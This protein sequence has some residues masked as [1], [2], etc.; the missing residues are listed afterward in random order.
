MV[1]WPCPEVAWA[2][3]WLMGTSNVSRGWV[4]GGVEN[5]WGCHLG[6][7]L[8]AAS[9]SALFGFGILFRLLMTVLLSIR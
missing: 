6:K 8:E 3:T 7:M 4:G 9:A 5:I 1:G 2:G